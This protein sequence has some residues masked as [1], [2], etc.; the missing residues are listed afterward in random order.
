[1]PKILFRFEKY[2]K[3]LENIFGFGDNGVWIWCGNLSLLSDEFMWSAVNVF[4]NSPKISDVTEKDV[5][6]FDLVFH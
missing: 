5:L 1:M 6:E 3:D 4:P 2:Q